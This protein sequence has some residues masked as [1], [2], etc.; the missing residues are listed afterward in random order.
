MN[1]TVLTPHQPKDTSHTPEGSDAIANFRKVV[2]KINAANN[3]D[4]IM[5]EV[6][7][8]ICA[9][10]NAERLT[11]YSLSV[12]KSCFVSRIKTGLDSFQDL[13]MPVTEMSIVGFSGLQKKVVNIEDVY[14]KSELKKLM[15]LLLSPTMST[16]VPV[17]EPNKC[18]RC[19]S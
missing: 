2:G 17:T 19:R 15:Q 10:F 5:A 3:L 16:N 8:D 13:Q 18:W 14:N 4:E 1:A 6:S 7:K 12:D 9:L 11:I